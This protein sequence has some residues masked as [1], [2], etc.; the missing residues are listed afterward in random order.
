MCEGGGQCER[1][2]ERGRQF[3]SQGERGVGSARE[4]GGGGAVRERHGRTGTGRGT[5]CY[6]S[7]ERDQCTRFVIFVPH[8]G[9]N[10]GANLKSIS[11]R[12]YLREAA[13]EWELTTETIYLPLGCLQGGAAA[14]RFW[15][16]SCRMAQVPRER[17][18]PKPQTLNP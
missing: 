11:R 17:V 16:W 13:F 5:E 3:E 10:P 15:T 2:R 9:G 4:R 18:E 6:S 12:Y 7:F 1:E 14:Q 8:P